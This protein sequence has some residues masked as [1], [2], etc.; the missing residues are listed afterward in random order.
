MRAGSN[1]ISSR[2]SSNGGG[3]RERDRVLSYA[4]K[5]LPPTS[6]SLCGFV[7]TNG[8]SDGQSLN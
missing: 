8:V 5:Y 7:C 1:S 4:R 3:W 6:L 2:G